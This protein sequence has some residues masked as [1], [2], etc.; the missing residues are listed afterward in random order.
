MNEIK[1]NNLVDDE[2]NKKVVH[3]II[4]MLPLPDKKKNSNNE[5]KVSYFIVHSWMATHL[6]LSGT[7]LLLYA[8]IFNFCNTTGR[9]CY[10]S[11]RQLSELTNMTDVT[12]SKSIK[13]LETKKLIIVDRIQNYAKNVNT[14]T[15]DVETLFNSL[16]PHKITLE[17][18]SPLELSDDI[19]ITGIQIDKLRKLALAYL[20]WK[21]SL[22]GTSE[23][24]KSISGNKNNTLF[25]TNTKTIDVTPVNKDNGDIN[26][27]NSRLNNVDTNNISNNITNNI[28]INTTSVTTSCVSE[29]TKSNT[30]ISINENITKIDSNDSNIK[31]SSSKESVTENISYLDD[32]RESNLTN[33][34][35]INKNDDKDKKDKKT[36]KN[37]FTLSKT[38]TTPEKKRR[39]NRN[40]E[41]AKM[42]VLIKQ[43][44]LN[45]TINEP[46]LVDIITKY[47]Q[48]RLDMGLEA[49]T[50]SFNVWQ[51]QLELL[52]KICEGD[53][54]YAHE[55]VTK[56]YLGQYR[57]MC[58][59]NQQKSKQRTGYGNYGNNRKMSFNLDNKD[60]HKVAAMSHEEKQKYFSQK[61]AVDD[62]GNPLL[63]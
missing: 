49:T 30:N 4:P 5:D 63:F 3:H 52:I 18:D 47:L 17:D 32:T 12:I 1:L 60:A 15:V 8:I 26:N 36:K 45:E 35:T 38:G 24:S 14:Y 61:I 54:E 50:L 33:S 2:N 55:I 7:P 40:K 57:T 13:E 48:G 43:M 23:E 11:R 6:K 28:N 59:P 22:A 44:F 10:C 25:D 42:F 39:Q 51:A 46:A 56:A 21:Q 19:D 53:Y 31:T 16:S 37:S 62:D 34:K 58:F 41:K 27:V 29:A 9:A 20:N